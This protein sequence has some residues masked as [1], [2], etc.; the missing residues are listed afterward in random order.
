MGPIFFYATPGKKLYDTG[1]IYRRTARRWCRLRASPPIRCLTGFGEFWQWPVTNGHTVFNKPS[2][3][4]DGQTEPEGRRR[5]RRG[6]GRVFRPPGISTTGP[7]AVRR[8]HAPKRQEKFWQWAG[9]Q[10]AADIRHPPAKL[11]VCA[12]DGSAENSVPPS[13]PSLAFESL[14]RSCHLRG[15]ESAV[16][17]GGIAQTSGNRSCGRRTL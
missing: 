7:S 8:R 14:T 2:A 9:S 6:R 11:S 15:P 3:D 12:T 10:T 16:R 1:N 17:R 5:K 13:L 4:A